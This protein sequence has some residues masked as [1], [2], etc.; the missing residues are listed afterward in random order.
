MPAL[1]GRPNKYWVPRMPPT[2][3]SMSQKRHSSGIFFKALASYKIQFLSNFYLCLKKK[4]EN[5]SLWHQNYEKHLTDRS[6]SDMFSSYRISE[7]A[8]TFCSFTKKK[9]TAWFAWF[10]AVPPQKNPEKGHQTSQIS[11]KRS[12][13]ILNLLS[14][15]VLP[16]GFCMTFIW[17]SPELATL[18]IPCNV[19]VGRYQW[20][21]GESL[22]HPISKNGKY[23]AKSC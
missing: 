22:T 8:E 3:N 11:S 15:K 7:A 4:G 20:S 17:S 9:G 6:S 21:W 18:S 16:L 1:A 23:M 12:L 2:K 5:T 10:F 14:N 19:P 13:A